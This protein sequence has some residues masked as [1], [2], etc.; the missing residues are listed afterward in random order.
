[1]NVYIHSVSIG[2]SLVVFFGIILIKIYVIVKK[3]YEMKFQHRCR[4][5]CKKNAA[6]KELVPVV[7]LLDDNVEGSPAI[8][9]NRRESLIFDLEPI[10]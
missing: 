5:Q 2:L 8:I 3:R 1:M 9:I 10:D 6:Q 4:F 7:E